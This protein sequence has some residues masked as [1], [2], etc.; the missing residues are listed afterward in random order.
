MQSV[1]ISTSISVVLPGIR[2][3]RSLESGEKQVSTLLSVALKPLI[4][5]RPSIDPVMTAVSSPYFCFT[6]VLTLSKRYSAVSEN[7]EKIST[8]LLP[9]LI[10]C[11]IFS[12]SSWNSSCS[13]VSCCGVISA[14]IKVNS[15][16]ISASFRSSSRQLFQSISARS[17]LTFLPTVKKSVF[18]SSMSKSSPVMSY[19]SRSAWPERSNWSMD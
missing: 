2:T 5:V 16:R 12:D 9:A 7:A 8:F 4:V 11:S 14:T 6:N 18:S 13:F 3:S 19:I 10:G 1:A 17:I 15:S